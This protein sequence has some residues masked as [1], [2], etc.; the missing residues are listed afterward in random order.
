MAAKSLYRGTAKEVKTFAPGGKYLIIIADPSGGVNKT[1]VGKVYVY[2]LKTMKLVQ[3]Y[4]ALYKADVT[5]IS[6][7]QRR[8]PYRAMFLMRGW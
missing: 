5:G 4:D 2:D 8:L 6:T 1:R 7:R 3:N